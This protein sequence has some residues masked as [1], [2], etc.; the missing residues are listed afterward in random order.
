MSHK[1]KNQVSRLLNQGGEWSK[2]FTIS[3]DGSGNFS[4]TYT[5]RG[6]VVKVGYTSGDMTAETVL[7]ITN[8]LGETIDTYDL[9]S[10]NATHLLDGKKALKG[11]TLTVSGGQASKTASAQ[12][13]FV[14]G[15]E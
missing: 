15:W 13:F 11:I 12:V 8:S 1:I 9:N 7:T 10:G 4:T 5:I 3:T 2:T 14:S 6:N